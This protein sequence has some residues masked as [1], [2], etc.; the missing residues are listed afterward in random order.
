MKDKLVHIEKIHIS[1]LVRLIN[2]VPQSTVGIPNYKVTTNDS[3]FNIKNWYTINGVS[4]FIHISEFIWQDRQI[5]I[6]LVNEN[7]NNTKSILNA[8]CKYIFNIYSID[9]II[10][11]IKYENLE[12]QKILTALGFCIDIR[13]R[14]HAFVNGKLVHTMELSLLR[15]EFKNE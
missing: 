4:D 9:K 12:L 3:I 5:K 7:L 10:I 1:N 11:E 2:S 8:F 15:E 6:W 14:Q 13:K